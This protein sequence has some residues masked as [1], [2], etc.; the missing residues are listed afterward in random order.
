MERRVKKPMSSPTQD[1][2]AV[3]LLCAK[4]G[5]GEA[6]AAA[7]PLTTRQ[8]FALEKWLQERSLRLRDLL[9]SRHLQRQAR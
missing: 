4:L 3:L 2:L 5:Q 7:K 1:T 8:Y 6:Q 9:R